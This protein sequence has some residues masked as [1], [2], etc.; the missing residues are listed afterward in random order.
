[1]SDREP[2][3][4]P[5][6]PLARGPMGGDQFT[7]IHNYVFRDSRL[8]AKAM[9][10]FGHLSTHKEGWQTDVK[11][12]ARA[13]R[14]GR[15]AIATGLQELERYHYLIRH[16]PRNADGTVGKPIWFYTDLPA[17]IRALGITDEAVVVD[18][19]QAAFKEWLA[20]QERNARSEP[21]PENPSTAPTSGNA[22]A[23]ATAATTAQQPVDN[24]ADSG[25]LPR[26]EPEPDFP[27]P[28]D[29]VPGN[30]PHKKNNNQNTNGENTNQGGPAPLEPPNPAAAAAGT[31][32]NR[33]RPSKKDSKRKTRSNPLTAHARKQRA[34]ELAGPAAVAAIAADPLISIDDLVGVIAR[35]NPRLT[36]AQAT[37]RAT[38][39]AAWTRKSNDQIPACVGQ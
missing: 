21:E 7:S 5:G 15:D 4:Y 28:A 38:T 35:S 26:S 36:Q 9:G 8:S 23:A 37:S 29:P 24:S 20:T 27:D 19:V 2:P 39:L 30:P 18:R 14:D 17:Q 33:N 13:M 1:M 10:I 34:C 22:D 11:T 31:N 25:H 16:Q 12:I 3:T 32:N 6:A